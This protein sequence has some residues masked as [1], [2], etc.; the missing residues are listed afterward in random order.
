MCVRAKGAGEEEDQSP[1]VS[2]EDGS[3]THVLCGVALDGEA[4]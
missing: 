1:G 2:D 3:R 4:T